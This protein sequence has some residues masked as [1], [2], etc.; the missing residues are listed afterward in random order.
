MAKKILVIDD[1]PIITMSCQKA[2]QSE[3]YDVHTSS[4]GMEGVEMFKRDNYDLVIVDNKMPG[5]DGFEVLVKVRAKRP[6]QKVII[7]SGYN[8]VEQFQKAQDYGASLYLEKPFTPDELLEA[9]KKTIG[10]T[11]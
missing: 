10:S 4:S 2:L 1:E 7:I 9:V 8:T 5:L 3:G 11:N 6:S